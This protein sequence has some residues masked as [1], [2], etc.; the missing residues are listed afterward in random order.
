[1]LCE[2]CGTE[3]ADDAKFCDACGTQTST[4]QANIQAQQEKNRQENPP[5]YLDLK[6]AI[7]ITIALFIVLPTTCL[8]ADIPLPVALAI[9]FGTAGGLGALCII[10]GIRNQFFKK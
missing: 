7:L 1:M 8:F 10:Q 2:K 5:A 6:A 4:E 3:I 9:G